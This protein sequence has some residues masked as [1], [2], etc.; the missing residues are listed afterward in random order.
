MPAAIGAAAVHKRG[1]SARRILVGSLTFSIACTVTTL[2]CL[3]RANARA[4]C[5]ALEILT[6]ASRM[7]FRASSRPSSWSR[8]NVGKS[9]VYG[10]QFHELQLHGF[11]YGWNVG[12]TFTG[13]Q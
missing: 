2:G 3:V 4:C 8:A 13:S 9:A 1:G 11:D 6:L 12:T 7:I 5:S 10:N